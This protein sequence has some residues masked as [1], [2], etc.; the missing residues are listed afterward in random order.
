[1][2]WLSEE[3]IYNPEIIQA[4]ESKLEK[5]W[6]YSWSAGDDDELIEQAIQVIAQTRKASATLL[7]RKLGVWF[8]RAARIM[9][10]M[11]ERW[12]IWPQEWAKPRDIFM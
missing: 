9:D 5:G 12:L 8:A 10:Q 2:K 7:Q 3:D 11:E 6:L 1:M 4:L